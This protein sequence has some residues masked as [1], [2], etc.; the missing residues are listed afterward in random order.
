MIIQKGTNKYIDS[1]LHFIKEQDKINIEYFCLESQNRTF[2]KIDSST[3]LSELLENAE[4]SNEEADLLLNYSGFNYKHIN[5]VLRD[6]WNYEDNGSIEKK[7]EYKLLA[8]RLQQTIMNH[9]TKLN[10]NVITYRG[11]DLN[12]FK[13]YG[14]ESM[15]EL[16]ELEGKYMLDRG[17]VST[18]VMEDRSFFEKENDLGL[19][20]NV[21][22]EYYIPCEFRDG[23]YLRG[24]I[25][26][27]PMQEEFLINSSNLSKVNSVT[28]N[29]NN[30]AVVK[31]TL[32]P[33][34]LYDDFYKERNN[35]CFSNNK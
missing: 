14:I 21:K 2:Q 33:K 15:K 10:D 34:E 3:K 18:S 16:K 35:S 32:I 4:L 20:Y 12:Y 23:I 25:S 13:Q 19:N 17:L 6:N 9:P 28:I 30:T 7:E 31:T 29:D 11:V 5:A 24:P 22:I 1:F 26:Y 8:R 27:T